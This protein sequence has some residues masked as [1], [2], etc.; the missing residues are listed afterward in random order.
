MPPKTDKKNKAMEPPPSPL[1]GDVLRKVRQSVLDAVADADIQSALVTA[2]VD[3]VISAVTEELQK[4]M[5][6]DMEA[7]EENQN[8]IL[9]LEKQVASLDNKCNQKYDDLE[10]YARRNNVRVFGVPEKDN[11]DTDNMVLSIFNDQ[12]GVPIGK[13]DIDRSHR[14]GVRSEDRPRAIIV[15]FVSYRRRAEV[16]SQKKKLKGSGVVVCEDLTVV[17]RQ[18]LSRAKDQLGT[19]NVWTEDGRIVWR[20]A[21][22][23]RKTATKMSDL[24]AG[25][26]RNNER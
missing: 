13:D 24:P 26:S 20:D 22:G 4:T 19:K 10:Q 25:G 16:F 17:R 1:S 8:K 11:E 2:I 5:T 6:F 7:V 3:K 23:K 15:K 12:L 21:A 9:A 14:V 18:I